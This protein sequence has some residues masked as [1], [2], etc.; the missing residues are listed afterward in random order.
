MNDD[1]RINPCLI[2]LSLFLSWQERDWKDTELVKKYLKERNPFEYGE[3]LCNLSDGV[4]AH[5]SVNA[6]TA[7]LVG[8]HI[9][10]KMIGL[11][12]DEYSGKQI[13]HQSRWGSNSG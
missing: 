6:D 7:E 8:E 12:A 11:S 10:S 13:H 2:S 5:A 9:I 3:D 1:I 4:H